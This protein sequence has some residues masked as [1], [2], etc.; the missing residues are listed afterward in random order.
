MKKNLS[1]LG[2]AG[3]FASSPYKA[4]PGLE[5]CPEVDRAG[6]SPSR[7][8]DHFPGPARAHAGFFLKMGPKAR[9]RPPGLTHKP[10][11]SRLVRGPACHPPGPPTIS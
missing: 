8:P 6:P 11:V 7:P 3:H 4:G 2:R 9:A 1:F 5:K 10:V